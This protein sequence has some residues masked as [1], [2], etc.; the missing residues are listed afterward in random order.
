MFRYMYTKNVKRVDLFTA[1]IVANT[2]Y[3]NNIL[4]IVKMNMT[5]ISNVGINE[6]RLYLCT[7]FMY[8][9]HCLSQS[10][11]TLL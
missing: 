4:N 11:R 3:D 1:T 8:Y 9:N 2:K 6:R 10:S 7:V 5:L